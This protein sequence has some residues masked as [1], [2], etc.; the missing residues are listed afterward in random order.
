M[1]RRSSSDAAR[2]PIPVAEGQLP[3]FP[4]ED[5]DAWWTQRPVVTV[6]EPAESKD[7]AADENPWRGAGN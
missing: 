2:R 1:S 3:L 7:G 5:G 4:P 6:D